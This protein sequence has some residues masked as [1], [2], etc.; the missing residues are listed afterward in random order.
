MTSQVPNIATGGAAGT[1]TYD[2]CQ[3][4]G[5]AAASAA[6]GA[7]MAGEGVNMPLDADDVPVAMPLPAI[8]RDRLGDPAFGTPAAAAPHSS[9][10]PQQMAA[11]INRLTGGAA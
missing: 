3:S 6:Y 10:S 8:P 5:Q 11:E 1:R 9:M 2:E 7:A 4:S